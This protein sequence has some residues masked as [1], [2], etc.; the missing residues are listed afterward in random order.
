M[1]LGKWVVV[2]AVAAGVGGCAMTLPLKGQMV[3]G[4]E[5][6]TGKATGYLDGGGTLELTSSKGKVCTGTFVYVTNRNGDGTFQCTNGQ[7]GAFS[8]VSTGTRG[9]GVGS[10]G[11]KQFTFTFG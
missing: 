11:G 7:S 6:F 4:E 5:T 1:A 3:T 8:F 9:T 2:A 10:I